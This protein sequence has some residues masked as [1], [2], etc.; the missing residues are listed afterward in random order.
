MDKSESGDSNTSFQVL[1]GRRGIAGRQQ[2]FIF[3]ECPAQK[4]RARVAFGPACSEGGGD[5][6]R[7]L[8]VLEGVDG[9]VEDHK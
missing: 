9:P 2:K 7:E 4:G 3:A 6:G 5:G 8:D 1:I